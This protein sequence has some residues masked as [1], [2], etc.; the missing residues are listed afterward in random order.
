MPNI[1]YYSRTSATH[2]ISL[3]WPSKCIQDTWSIWEAATKMPRINIMVIPSVSVHWTCSTNR[4]LSIK[5][6]REN[7]QNQRNTCAIYRQRWYIFRKISKSYKKCRCFFPLLS[8]IAP[9]FLIIMARKTAF[10]NEMILKTLKQHPQT[11]PPAVHKTVC[12]DDKMGE[13]LTRKN[14]NDQDNAKLFRN[15]LQK[16]LTVKEQITPT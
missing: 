4:F 16:Y 11:V 15:V 7:G 1:W 2:R 13:I 12:L 10:V 5:R 9:L 3:I 6:T 8:I 14:V